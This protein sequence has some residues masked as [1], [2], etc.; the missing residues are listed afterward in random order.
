VLTVAVQDLLSATEER[1][2][3][4]TPEEVRSLD[5]DAGVLGDG[6]FGSP[7]PTGGSVLLDGSFEVRFGGGSS[8]LTGA[9]FLDFGQVW[10]DEA[11]TRLSSLELTPGV[12][13]RYATPIGP[14]R[15]DLAYS[16]SPARN[17][18][19]VT[20]QIRPFDPATDSLPDRIRVTAPDGSTVTLDY[21]RSEELAPLG[22]RVLFGEAGTFDLSRFQLHVSIGQAF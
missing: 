15:V 12:G 4:C 22:P 7:R 10:D 6:E 8:N 2:A 20:S 16:F 21:V 17:L 11:D 5:C 9:A 3:A 14:I 18:P 1:T 13:V 19:V